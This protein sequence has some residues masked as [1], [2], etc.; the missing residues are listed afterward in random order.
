[1]FNIDMNDTVYTVQVDMN[2]LDFLRDEAH[3]TSLKNGCGEGACGACMILM[4][5]KA[6]RACLLTVA[7]VAGKKLLTVEGLSERE[8]EAYVW[9]FAQAGAVQCG[10]CIPGMVISAKALLDKVPNPTPQEIKQ[11]LR[12]NICRCTGYVKIEEGILLAAKVLRGELQ[13]NAQSGAGIGTSIHRVDARE[14]VLGTGQYVDDMQVEQMLHAAVLRTQYPRALVKAIDIAAARVSPGVEAVLTAVDIPGDHDHGHI[15]HDWPTLVSVGQETRYIGD[16]I[17]LVAAQTKQQARAALA[18][19]QVD[20]EELEPLLTPTQALAEQAYSIHPKGNLL[21]TTKINRGHAQEALAQSAHVITQHYSTPPTEHAFM[22]PESALAIPQSD[23]GITIYVADQSVYDDQHGIMGILGLPA[24]KVRVISKLV[25]G[26]FGGK[27]DLTVQHHAALLALK[28]QKP[29]KLTLTRKES[30]LVHPKRHAMELDITTGCDEAG[31]LTAMLASIVADTGAYASLGT[32]VLQRAC[33]HASGPY[34]IPN[35]DI[36]GICV[37]TNNPPAGAFRG[38]GVTQSAFG[39]EIN[40]DLLAEKVGISPWEIRFLNAL[41]P[42]MINSTGQIADEGT[43]IKET[44]LAVREAYESHPH[45]AGIASCMKNTGIGVGLSDTGRVKLNI[46]KGNVVVLTSAACIGQGFATIATQIVHEA[47]GLPLHLIEVGFPDTALTPDSGT[48]TASR[49]TMFTGEATRQA[50]LKLQQAL[51]KSSLEELE[52]SEFIGEY[53]GKTDSMDSDKPNPI[54]H[55]AYSYATQVVLLNAEGKVEK[56]VAAH[57][58]GRAINPRAIEG[59]IEGG[60][61]MGLG[62]ALRED[63]PL[64]KGVPTAKFG[65]LGL[66]R[67]TEVPE[68]ECI[69]I[70]KNSSPLAYGAKGVG[71]IASIPTA[72]AVASAYYKYDGKLRCSLPLRETPYK[73]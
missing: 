38:F 23:G 4:D 48:T 8:R 67:S 37:Y 35:V 24:E 33:T 19:I 72:P 29:V 34:Q 39:A 57:D 11:G 27:E 71:E 18:L 5:G 49:Q 3:I 41:E 65:T 20:Y 70:E 64:E 56:V 54:S 58:V 22:E 30:L 44:L 66:F 55:V 2:L 16:A 15:F 36:T 25:G 43:A 9:A 12:G 7:K 32:A 6:M 51:Y 73:K 21:S 10:F 42:G 60:V 1:M 69:I 40:L 17:V 62:Y 46:L 13:A 47:T 14:K 53:L 61:T 68:I 31:K 63:F 50:A 28:T 45:A 26:G 59:Q 52:E